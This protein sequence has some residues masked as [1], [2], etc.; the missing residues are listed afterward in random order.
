MR[1][2]YWFLQAV[3]SDCSEQPM[4]RP[5]QGLWEM[6]VF[7]DVFSREFVIFEPNS[8]FITAVEQD[9]L[10]IMEATVLSV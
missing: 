5:H 6:A 9:S 1:P 3:S 10:C 4:D 7:W 2:F 8:P